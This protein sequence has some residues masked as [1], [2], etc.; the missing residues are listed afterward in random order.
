MRNKSVRDM[1]LW[2]RQQFSL[3]SKVFRQAV[4]GAALLGVIAL[5]AAVSLNI[6]SFVRQEI[7]TSIGMARSTAALA[8]AEVDMAG[9]AK[10]V[11]EAYD[12]LSEEMRQDRSSA[13]YRAQFSHVRY[14]QDYV[15]LQRILSAAYSADEVDDIYIGYYDEKTHA[16]VFIG[17]PEEDVSAGYFTG[18]WERVS[19][20]EIH[21]FNH[22][23]GEGALYHISRTKPYGF[24][25]TSGVPIYDSEGNIACFALA[26]V[27]FMDLIHGVR[28]YVVQYTIALYV[29]VCFVGFL[30]SFRMRKMTVEPINE[31]AEAAEKYAR[32]RLNGIS[33]TEHFSSLEIH[34]KDEVENLALVMSDMEEALSEYEEDL[35]RITA[36][37]E[38]I[39][40]ELMLAKRIQAN[41]LPSVFPAFPERGEFDI[42]ASMDPAK[43]VGGDFYDFFLTDDDHLAM[44]IADVSGKGVPAALFMMASKIVISNYAMLGNSPKE[45]LRM[46]NETI[47]K[48]NR[49]EMFVTVWMGILEISTGKV[50]AANAGHENPVL[51]DENGHFEM[52]KDKHGLVIGFMSGVRYKE[53]E[54]TMK[55]GSRLF[56]YT[57]GVPEAT[58]AEEELFGNERMMAAV[59]AAA[60]VPLP[61]FLGKIRESVDAFVKDAPQFDDLTMMALEYRGQEIQGKGEAENE[62][63]ENG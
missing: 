57:D 36:E 49:E 12:S 56:L 52:M 26:D 11:R 21:K 54:F 33:G 8:E 48:S 29:V 41:M 15:I 4:V 18:G 24:L 1:R 50:T 32:D 58:S 25:C 28:D 2:E 51:S 47:C 10:K 13:A 9:M 60:A 27:T 63:S 55:P 61:A 3:E 43:E 35:T 46:A 7:R 37:K 22:W 20:N 17:V 59:R 62:H 34:T 40:T 38:R 16:L 30:T 44:V 14:S 53:Y 39:S 23:D 45:V 5:L 31:I 42:Y 19:R 6:V